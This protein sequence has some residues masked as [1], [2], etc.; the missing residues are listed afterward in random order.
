MKAIVN[1]IEYDVW[2]FSSQ[3]ELKMKSVTEDYAVETYKTMKGP[4]ESV[5]LIGEECDETYSGLFCFGF[6]YMDG[7]LMILNRDV[8]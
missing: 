6:Q 7:D 3:Y 4:L 2:D 1:G 5:R 8:P